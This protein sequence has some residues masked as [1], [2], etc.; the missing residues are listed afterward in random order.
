MPELPDL[1]NSWTIFVDGSKRVS[2]AGAGVVLVSPQGDRMRN[3]LRM[4]FP[5][6]SNNEAEYEA[7]LQDFLSSDLSNL[8]HEAIG[9]IPWVNS[10]IYVNIIFFPLGAQTPESYE[11]K[12]TRLLSSTIIVIF[13]ILQ[14]C[15]QPNIRQQYTPVQKNLIIY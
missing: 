5:N 2:G 8:E 10:I 4:R 13:D 11:I 6:P 12:N 9:R 3:V 7:V 14:G 15:S 1:S